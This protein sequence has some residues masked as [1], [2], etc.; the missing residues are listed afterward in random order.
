M[1][2]HHSFGYVLATSRLLNV[3]ANSSVRWSMYVLAVGVI[4]IG[5]ANRVFAFIIHAAIKRSGLLLDVER[6]KGGKPVVPN[7][8]IF[9]KINNLWTKHITLPATFGYRH[10]QP[11]AFCTIPTRLQSILLFVY[12]ALNFIFCCVDYHTFEGNT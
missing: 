4:L 5:V 8:G 9:N 1:Y 2:I 12:V 11:W 3:R 7:R 6:T 10:I